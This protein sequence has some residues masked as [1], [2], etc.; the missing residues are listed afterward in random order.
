MPRGDHISL[1]ADEVEKDIK[2]RGVRFNQAFAWAAHRR[3]VYFGENREVYNTWFTKVR[4]R[5]SE[6]DRKTLS[7]SLQG[8][9]PWQHGKIHQS[10]C[11][12]RKW[13]DDDP[14]GHQ[15]VSNYVFEDNQ[16][17]EDTSPSQTPHYFTPRGR[18]K[19]GIRSEP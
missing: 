2:E 17:L 8:P 7:Q 15:D 13:R 10:T 6:R 19:P 11:R 12:R 16:V 4:K 9:R 5:L 18:I 14:W 3:G 1:M